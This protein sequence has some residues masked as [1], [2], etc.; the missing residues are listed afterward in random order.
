MKIS[1]R[2]TLMHVH[3]HLRRDYSELHC[4]GSEPYSW[5]FP[6]FLLCLT[7][8]CL[9][10]WMDWRTE[11]KLKTGEQC[12]RCNSLCR[13]FDA[14]TAVFD[15]FPM[16]KLP[17]ICITSRY[18]I[19]SLRNYEAIIRYKSENNSRYLSEKISLRLSHFA[20]IHYLIFQSNL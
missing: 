4:V 10:S 18:F 15:F 5:V 6:P 14:T 20:F 12:I 8:W 19:I 11:L 13:I 2:Q 17:S 7:E 16:K 3:I 9:N 1:R